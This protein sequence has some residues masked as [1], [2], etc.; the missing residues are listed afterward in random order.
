VTRFAYSSTPTVSSS[1]GPK[2]FTEGRVCGYPTCTTRLSRYNAE[3][4]CAL[5]LRPERPPRTTR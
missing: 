5:H 2:A 3:A 4:L 1:R